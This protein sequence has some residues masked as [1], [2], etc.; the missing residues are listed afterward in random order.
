MEAFLQLA[1]VLLY[2]V[3]IVGELQE[4]AHLVA[5]VGAEEGIDALG[6]HVGRPKEM[7]L[8]QVGMDDGV[9]KQKRVLGL[10]KAALQVADEAAP[11]SSIGTHDS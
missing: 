4:P 2:K 9:R 5:L 3:G 1:H 7:R 10:V 11:P 8:A 6:A